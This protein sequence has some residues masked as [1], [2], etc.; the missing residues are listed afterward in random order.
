MSQSYVER[1]IGLLATD[2]ALRRE[3]MVSP[4]AALQKMVESGMRLN[5]CELQS[6]AS[7][8]PYELAR[9]ADVIDARLQKIDL[10]KEAT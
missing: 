6:L 4:R 9:F 1:V 3:F 2:E 5:P 10:R 8:N 7:L